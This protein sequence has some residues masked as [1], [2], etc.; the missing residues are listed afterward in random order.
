MK[1][2]DDI[3]NELP[4]NIHFQR[5]VRRYRCKSGDITTRQVRRYCLRLSADGI[6]HYGGSFNT[7]EAAKAALPK[8][9]RSIAR[10]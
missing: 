4:R 2:T 8:F 3:G 1:R 6:D 10:R 7:L 5:Q 9:L